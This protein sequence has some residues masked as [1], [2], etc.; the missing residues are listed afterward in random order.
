MTLSRRQ[1]IGAAIAMQVAAKATGATNPPALPD[2]AGFAVTPIAYLD[3]ASIHPISLGAR[4]AMDA[5]VAGRTLDPAAPPPVDRAATLA[6]FAR[7]VNADPDEVTW[8]QST[9][10]GEQAVLRVLGFPGSGGRI[11][12]DTPH[13]YAA[14]PAGGHGARNH[15]GHQAGQPVARVHL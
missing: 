1:A 12:T 14:D 15:P 10:A 3:S 13:F 6:K 8:V 5:Y 11:V 2:K 7:L 4:R 9:T